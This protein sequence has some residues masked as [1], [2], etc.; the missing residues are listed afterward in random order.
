MVCSQG[1]AL[2]VLVTV[3]VPCP[4]AVT[5][6]HMHTVSSLLSTQTEVKD[7]KTFIRLR[8]SIYVCVHIVV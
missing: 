5:Q 6:Q 4:D 7:S 3:Y 1:L 8:D 2:R